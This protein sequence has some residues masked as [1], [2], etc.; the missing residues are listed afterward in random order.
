MIQVEKTQTIQLDDSLI[1]VA[2]CSDQIKQLVVYLDDWRQQEVDATSKLLLCRAALNDLR[3]SMIQQLQKEAE[4][5][6]AAIQAANDGASHEQE[7]EEAAFTEVPN[8]TKKRKK[9]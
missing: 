1:E 9:G 3:N 4:D 2:N 5:R 8:K 6:E 7:N